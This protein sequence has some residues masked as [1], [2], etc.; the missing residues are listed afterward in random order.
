M[1]HPP[2]VTREVFENVEHVRDAFLEEGVLMQLFNATFD[3]EW[4]FMRFLRSS[5]NGAPNTLELVDPNPGNAPDPAQPS[6][7]IFITDIYAAP[8]C[9]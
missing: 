1:G 9:S 8:A 6:T 4:K 7:K 5:P 2:E 3:L